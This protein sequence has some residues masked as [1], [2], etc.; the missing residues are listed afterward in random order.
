[1]ITPS[2]THLPIAAQ[3]MLLHAKKTDHHY[4][5]VEDHLIF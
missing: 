3:D 2:F 1:M 4:G 5:D